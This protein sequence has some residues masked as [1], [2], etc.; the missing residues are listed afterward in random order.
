MVRS[1]HFRKASHPG[2]SLKEPLIMIAQKPGPSRRSQQSTVVE[3]RQRL[4]RDLHDGLLQA[5]T[6]IALQLETTQRLLADQNT[7][8]ARE[9]LQAIQ[10][11]LLEEQGR[12]RGLIDQLK[13]PRQAA[14]AA[15]THWQARLLGLAQQIELEWGLPAT[16]SIQGAV[17]DLP[18][19]LA[20]DIY[21][22]VCEA[23][24][25]SA[26]H[27][28]ATRGQ[29]KIAVE[30]DRIRIRVQDNGRGFAFQGR[31]DL[32]QLTLLGWG[33]QSLIGRIAALRGQLIL[34]SSRSGSCLDIIVPREKQGRS[35]G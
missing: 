5:L 14:T 23:L 20:E 19:R 2:S 32:A 35:S 7:D 8:A 22:L 29:A 12:L 27:A 15:N 17:A 31:Y 11:L 21:L 6:G 25:N 13:N 33:P 4:A 34:K 3:E 28:G 26:R 10:V 1:L 30:P 9:R 16:V 18:A 24:T